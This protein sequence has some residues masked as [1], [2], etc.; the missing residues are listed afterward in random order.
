M[1]CN[2]ERRNLLRHYLV[3]SL[4]RALTRTWPSP[5]HT[6]ILYL[7]LI[8]TLDS[9][10]AV[11]DFCFDR[12]SYLP[13]VYW[14]RD[15]NCKAASLGQPRNVGTWVIGQ[16]NQVIYWPP[17]SLLSP[18]YSVIPLHN[19]SYTE[20]HWTTFAR[21]GGNCAVFI[22]TL[23]GGGIFTSCLYSLL[24]IFCVNNNLHTST[25]FDLYK[26]R[27]NIAAIGQLILSV[28]RHRTP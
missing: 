15:R 6:Q 22:T 19:Y 17:S 16:A 9:K 20:R 27:G 23:I 18:S 26:H 2:Q 14:R 5:W 21:I 12:L 13:H 3:A 7:Y 4:F 10:T 11:Y 24:I 28:T 1:A 25:T 8:V